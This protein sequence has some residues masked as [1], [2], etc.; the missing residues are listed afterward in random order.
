[1]LTVVHEPAGVSVP[2]KLSSYRVLVATGAPAPLPAN[3]AGFALADGA[4]A[5]ARATASAGASQ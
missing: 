1:V 4:A 3:P 2:V 5:E